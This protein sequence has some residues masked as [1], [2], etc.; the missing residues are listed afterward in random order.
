MSAVR[1][2]GLTYWPAFWM[3]GADID[4]VGTISDA[5]RA[6]H[7]L[8]HYLSFVDNLTGIDYLA[9]V[10]SVVG[11]LLVDYHDIDVLSGTG[12]RSLRYFPT[13]MQVVDTAAVPLIGADERQHVAVLVVDPIT[14]LVY[15]KVKD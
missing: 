9:R 14:G 12:G 7:L 4:A 10:S 13:E 3:L 6:G 15:V 8:R 5:T 2:R 11:A 1:V